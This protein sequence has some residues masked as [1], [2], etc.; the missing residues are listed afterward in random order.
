[1]RDCVHCDC[2]NVC[3]FTVC[4]ARKAKQNG[5]MTCRQSTPPSVRKAATCSFQTAGR[6]IANQP[7]LPRGGSSSRCT[8]QRL[9]GTLPYSLGQ[10]AV[11]TTALQTIPKSP[12]PV[13]APPE[14]RCTVPGTLEPLHCKDSGQQHS[15]GFWDQWGFGEW[16]GQAT[17]LV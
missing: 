2:E 11:N 4:L 16:P 6:T 5:S 7:S 13:K 15:T 10:M 14:T 1:M 8:T 9:P 12:F 3:V 17:R